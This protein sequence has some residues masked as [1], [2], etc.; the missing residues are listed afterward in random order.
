VSEW[1]DIRYFLAVSR[2]G[3]LAGAGRELKVEATTVGRR[4]VA[5]EQALGAR[6]FDRTTDGFVLTIAGERILENARH[7]EEQMLELERKACGED[8]KLEGVVRLATSENLAVGFLLRV[9]APIHERH[10][11]IVLD[12]MTG[13]QPAD[14][15]KR[16]AD[17]AVRVGPNMRPTQQSLVAKKL[18]TIGMTLYASESYL[19]RHGAP[20]LDQGLEGHVVCAYGGEI[21]S[22]PP[23]A[24]LVDNG[25]KARVVLRINSM[26][27]ITRSVAAGVGLSLL[28]CFLG[29][30]EPLLRRVSARPI[31]FSEAWLVVHPDIQRT[32]RVR[33]VIDFLNEAMEL[34]GEALRGE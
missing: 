17:L 15:N 16:E 3:T 23:A 12:V 1:S 25:A 28:P 13:A 21:A 27:G 26:L 9:L 4:L 11:G 2:T 10:P 30:A 19:E 29:D 22:I 34:H 18:V 8:A 6:L 5:F 14:L 20:R 32:A 31:V 33:A 24:W 7:V